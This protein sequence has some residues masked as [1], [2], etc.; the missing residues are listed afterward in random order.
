MIRLST[1]LGAIT[2]LGVLCST[3]AADSTAGKPWAEGVTQDRQDRANQLFAEANELFAQKAHPAALEKYTAAVALWN[4][5]M[6]RFNMAVT[7]IRL[8]RILEAADSLAAALRFDAL[9]FTP[10]LYQQALDYQKL[11]GDRIGTVQASCTQPSVH[12]FLDGAP[13]FTCPGT[14]T[15]R[16]LTGEHAV[17]GERDGFIKL[18]QRVVVTGGATAATELALEPFDSLVRFEYPVRRWIPWTV[19]GGGIAVA[20]VGFGFWI[21]GRDGLDK[22]ETDYRILCPSGCSNEL[23]EQPL[24]ADAE[25]RALF[26]VD[27]GTALMIT[28]GALA[29]GGAVWAIVNRPQRVVPQ[30]EVAPTAGGMST[31]ARWT[32]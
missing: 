24:L 16:V 20:L 3:V 12:V 13:W 19:T 4:H 26:R 7:Q 5:P 28:G 18:A 25:N 22:F 17:T 27:L 32:F 1:W 8:D 15:R 29:V 30:I 23:S 9:P 11:V 21:S 14:Q 31:T 10:A 6:I 2:T